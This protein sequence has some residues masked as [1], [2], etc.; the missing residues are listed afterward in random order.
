MNHV[1]NNKKTAQSGFTLV[2]LLLAM[3]FVSLLLAAITM[4]V[5]QMTNIYAKGLTMRAVDQA[6]QALSQD[7]RRAI[8]SARPLSVGTDSDGGINYKPQV[9]FGGDINNPDGGRLCTGS[10]SYIW[11]FGKSFSSPINK[12][13]TGHSELIRLVKIPDNG[14]IYCSD[15]ESRVDFSRAVEMLNAGDRELAL[16]SLDIKAVTNSDDRQQVLYQVA[17]ELGTNDAEALEKDLITLDTSCKPPAEAQGLK[18]Y[19][20]V[21]KFEFTARAGNSGGGR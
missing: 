13:T 4:T 15:P 20:A 10:Y 19:C 6:G 5:I 1:T 17:F 21:N 2:E 16:Q 8:E 14:A 18:D 7:M 9:A 11:N 3:T 12:Y